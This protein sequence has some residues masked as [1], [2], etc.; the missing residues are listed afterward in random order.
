MFDFSQNIHPLTR[1]GR[2]QADRQNLRALSPDSARPDMRDEKQLL[3]YL[4]EFAKA[5]IFV[6]EDGT[7]DNWQ[8]FFRTG[9]SVQLA[10]I[11]QYNPEVLQTD[12]RDAQMRLAD[13]LE[14]DNFYPLLDFIFETALSIN[15]W[16]QALSNDTEFIDGQLVINEN[17]LRLTIQNLIQS[18][19]QTALK[20]LIGTA[21]S[22]ADFKIAPLSIQYQLADN[23]TYT[24]YF[25]AEITKLRYVFPTLQE[26]TR[27]LWDIS[28]A[29]FTLRNPR[30]QAVMN[31][32]QA[33]NFVAIDNLNTL[34]SIFYKAV[35]KIVADTEGVS[36]LQPTQMHEPHLGLLYA[37]L[38]LFGYAQ[39]DLNGLPERHL[40]FYFQQ[41]LGLK[42]RPFVADE[43]HLIFE[44]NKPFTATK[45][46]EKT[47]VKDGKDSQKVE[48]QFATTDELIATQAQVAVLRTL[49]FNKLEG[50]NAT[51]F[52]APIANSADGNG[53]PFEPEKDTSWAAL[54]STNTP[55]ARV[56][57]LVASPVLRLAEGMRTLTLTLNLSGNPMGNS[58]SKNVG[59]IPVF[60]IQLSGKKGWFRPSQ[61]PAF[62]VTANT[63]TI[64]II[65]NST[66]E[67]VVVAD[68]SVLKVDFGIKEPLMT[69]VLNHN[70][71]NDTSSLYEAFKNTTLKNITLKTVVDGVTNF[72]VQ[73]QNGLLDAKKPFQPFGPQPKIGD[74]F[75]V[76]SN[77]AFRKQ[78]TNLALKIEWKDLPADFAVQY[79]YY[80]NPPTKESI[81]VDLATFQQGVFTDFM[82]SA[83]P[84][85]QVSQLFALPKLDNLSNDLLT[86]PSVL[87]QFLIG[88]TRQGFIRLTLNQP[89]LH[90]QYAAVAQKRAGEI[91]KLAADSTDDKSMPLLPYT[92]TIQSLTLNYEAMD[93][94]TENLQ[95]FH[96]HPF[97]ETNR[98]AIGV[99]SS[100]LPKFDMIE[101][102]INKPVMPI[103]GALY[104]GL[105]DSK[106][107]ETLSI[108]FQLNEPTADSYLAA[109]K[110]EWSYLVDNQWYKL[111]D[112]EHIL[113]DTTGGF[114]KS[115]IV[116]LVMPVGIRSEKT[117]ILPPQYLWIRA[118]TA[119]RSAA[120][121][122]VIGVHTQAVK[123]VFENKGNDLLRLDAPL[124][125]GA[126]K[127][128]VEP[129]G[130]IKS[131]TQPYDTFGGRA[132]ETNTAF[133][134]RTSETL[135]H[136]GRAITLND[137]E[138]LV[139]A[140]FPDVYKVKCITHTL[141][142][143]VSKD[144][145]DKLIAPGFVTVVVIPDLATRP[146]SER[147]EPRV[148]RGRLKDITD[149]L[150]SRTAPFVQLNVMNPIF[151]PIDTTSKITFIK[152]KSPAFYKNQLALDLKRYLAPWAFDPTAKIEF[153]G[154]I[155][156]TAI[157]GFI[158]Q[159]DY[160]DYIEDFKVSKQTTAVSKMGL[161]DGDGILTTT[162]ARGIFISGNHNIQ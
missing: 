148:S 100:L 75:Y 118:A 44:T 70:I 95:I 9:S 133:Y 69:L 123:A 37:F 93:T 156:E 13:G 60:D 134:K 78:L 104:I 34:F 144:A 64:T 131:V 57:L 154:Q 126:L 113:A 47:L 160:V 67:A 18:N 88:E 58:I 153:G 115:G 71:L 143:K 155:F 136:K 157:L 152:G 140:A 65:L 139:L 80:T 49:H 91:A 98:E 72:I 29:D 53:A 30:L 39:T 48:I 5:V 61:V 1:D 107:N 147:F 109:S 103:E 7:Q 85:G 68:P 42:P 142:Q 96:L 35:S 52:A 130:E 27:V 145:K 92:P 8:A 59:I 83:I 17:P 54:G 26:E 159:R 105:K 36:V 46:V 161:S 90:E 132:P 116:R 151:E 79:K 24:A 106:A 84:Q 51:L 110:I 102:E 45:I 15:R 11:A 77:E 12:F 43:A 25:A 162:T 62:V 86:D 121:C 108:L 55:K 3:A 22:I 32:P 23:E 19:L 114:I 10:L 28:D 138:S 149:F 97:D 50:Q 146:L 31:T 127:K 21:N 20:Q 122:R 158:E 38:R 89:L 128:M 125:A 41:V 74:Y 150:K 120:T 112:G 16:H 76:G 101:P 33:F 66:D 129:L 119:E 94:P 63:M 99:G 111:N 56:G 73:N 40:K 137:Y 82:P 81:T 87:T 4:Y 14:A 6:D 135:R 141:A 124:L 117:T 2:S